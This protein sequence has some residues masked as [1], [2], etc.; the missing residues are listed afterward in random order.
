M[1]EPAKHYL[2]MMRRQEAKAQGALDKLGVRRRDAQGRSLTLGQR[3]ELVLQHMRERERV[4][5]ALV[6]ES[7]RLREHA[8]SVGFSV[9]RTFVP[10]WRDRLMRPFKPVQYDGK[11]SACCGPAMER[12]RDGRL[13]VFDCEH[14]SV[15]PPGE[16]PPPCP[17]DECPS[18]IH[19]YAG[20]GI[21]EEVLDRRRAR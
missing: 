15:T 11:G 13:H 10:K 18:W 4:I 20:H 9:P 14:L 1:T 7:K 16:A 21:I 12:G 17:G 6:E 8:G 19:H 2:G 3:A 5:S